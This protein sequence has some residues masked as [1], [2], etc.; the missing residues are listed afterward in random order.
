MIFWCLDLSCFESFLIGKFHADSDVV[1]LIEFD[2][3]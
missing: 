1:S 2:P 3:E